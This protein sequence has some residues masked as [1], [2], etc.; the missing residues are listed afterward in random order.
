MIKVKRALTAGLYLFGSGLSVQAHQFLVENR[1][2]NV[3][4]CWHN[5]W[6]YICDV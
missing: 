4:H 1:L 2:C 3:I 6:D 5:P